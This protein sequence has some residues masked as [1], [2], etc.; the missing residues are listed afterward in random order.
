MEQPEEPSASHEEMAIAR[1]IFR[2][3][4]IPRGLGFQGVA[5]DGKTEGKK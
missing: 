5:G 3:A 1:I 2:R 4:D